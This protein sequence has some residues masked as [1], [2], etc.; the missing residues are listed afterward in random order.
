M[1]LL[2][3]GIQTERLVCKFVCKLC[4]AEILAHAKECSVRT[5]DGTDLFV[6]LECPE[7]N[8]LNKVAV[9][10]FFEKTD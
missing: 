8:M 7:C 2:K 5:S 3:P 6:E 1:E 9:R 10:D 4:R